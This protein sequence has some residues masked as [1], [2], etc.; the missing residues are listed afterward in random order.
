MSELSPRFALPL[1]AAGQSQK[2]IYHNEAVVALEALVQPVAQTLGDS[3]PPP[4][5]AIGASWIVGAAATG[6][7]AGQGET[8][9]RWTAGGWRFT[10]PID[11][12]AFWIA[13]DG[14]WAMRI[15][16]A[17]KL[18]LVPAQRLMNGGNQV[19]GARQPA[20]ADP[21][22]GTTIDAAARGAIAAIL[23]ALRNHGLITL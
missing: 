20:I 9:A 17:W 18:G 13:S 7:W 11:G 12:M 1:L 21:A 23:A 22:G 16:G 2:E 3:S 6:D 4:S 8:V 19:V 5:P 10:A 14:L 15:A